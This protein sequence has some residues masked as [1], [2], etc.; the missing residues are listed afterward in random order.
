MTR[1]DDTTR[2]RHM[3]NHSREALALVN[4]KTRHDLQAD[5]VLELALT[6]LMEIVG[7]AA[8]RV[9][10]ETRQSHPHIPW[11]EITG[12]RN[13]LVHGYDAVDLEILWNILQIDMPTLVSTL[14]EIMDNPPNDSKRPD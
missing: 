12:L 5:R 4:G 7:E 9:S 14:R 11:L 6:R 3:L 1:H 10:P 2:P 8:S 13:R